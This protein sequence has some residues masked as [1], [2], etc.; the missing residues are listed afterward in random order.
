MYFGHRQATDMSENH[1]QMLVGCGDLSPKLA[2]PVGGLGTES[3][4]LGLLDQ[5]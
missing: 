2:P 1:P 4:R 5:Y 3:A